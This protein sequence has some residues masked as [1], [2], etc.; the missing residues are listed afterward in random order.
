MGETRG[1]KSH[2]LEANPTRATTTCTKFQQQKALLQALEE[3]ES[4]AALTR[5]T[6][7][8]PW[9]VNAYFF[10]RKSVDFSAK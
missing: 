7:A 3:D 10:F 4:E 8:L 5:E 9:T 2:W 6:Q 1:K